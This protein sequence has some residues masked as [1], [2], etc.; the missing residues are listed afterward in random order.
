MFN[1][2]I[3]GIEDLDAYLNQINGLLDN[4]VGVVT[5]TVTG[6]I[7][8]TES[9]TIIGYLYKYMHIK[10]ADDRY[11][12]GLS[13]SPI[14]KS[15]YGLS[16]SDDPTESVNYIDYVWYPYSF[17]ATNELY[18]VV[19]GGRNFK[20]VLAASAPSTFYTGDVGT[21]VDLDIVSSAQNLTGPIFSS[22]GVTG[23]TSQTGTGTTFVMSNSPTLVTPNLGTP[24]VL[25]GTNITGTAAGLTAGNATLAATATLATT[26]TTNANLTGPITS[27]GNAT[28]VAS[29]T[30]TGS[31]FVMDTSPTLVTPDI[32]VAS[33]TSLSVTGVVKTGGYTVGTLP[34]GVTGDRAYVTD[35]LAPTFGNAVVGGGA[36]VIPVFKNATTWIV[37]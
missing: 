13:D 24:S 23:I 28:A 34:A 18:Y 16:N 5:N 1:P 8:D 21:A 29:Q 37:G 11:G 27:T 14:G 35:A 6:E 17:G 31:K 19:N 26:V 12:A 22:A 36:V 3:T 2:P 30:G 32:G 25:I 4:R 33:G 7:Y 20:Y 15:Y 10:Y 9:N